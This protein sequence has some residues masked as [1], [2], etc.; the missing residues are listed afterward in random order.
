MSVF[1]RSFPE[2]K[3][4]G[5]MGVETHGYHYRGYPELEDQLKSGELKIDCATEFGSIPRFHWSRLEDVPQ[6]AEGF[7]KPD[8]KNV[9]KWQKRLA[10][11]GDKPR[12]G[13]AWRSSKMTADRKRIY[14]NIEDLLPVLR[15]PGVEFVNVQ[16]DDC[17]EDIAK[18]R[19]E[20][21]ITIHAWD[22]L[23]LKDD[24][25]N[26]LA[27]MKNLDLIIGPPST[28]AIMGMSVGIPV[29]WL[30]RH[31]P[32][33]TFGTGAV[34]FH[35]QGSVTIG[36]VETPWLDHTP[37]VAERLA[38]AVKAGDFTVE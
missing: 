6:C 15:T 12:V 19:D 25:E 37:G 11:L 14:L 17:A 22:D 5:A 18:I 9:A 32:W 16:Y 27:M 35:A 36:Q 8:D 2:A 24:F 33:W 21:G 7:L 3:I 13:L 29:W 23:D 4:V 34:P 10:T 26:T 20:Y 1:Q 31:T 38:R 28:P 30:A